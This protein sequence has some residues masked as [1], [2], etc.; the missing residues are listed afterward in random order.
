MKTRTVILSAF[1]AL[2][3]VGCYTQ[4]STLEQQDIPPETTVDSTGDTVR[5]VRRVDTIVTRE[6]EVCY[7]ERDLLGYPRLRC[8][9][10]YYPRDWYRYN[11]VPWWYMND[12]YWSDYDRCPRLYFYDPNCGCCKYYRD[13]PIYRSPSTG[14]GAPRTPR[15]N[16]GTSRDSRTTRSS[17][18]TGSSPVR[19]SS[20]RGTAR[21]LIE[22]PAATPADSAKTTPAVP[23]A[24]P[25]VTPGTSIEAPKVQQQP[26]DTLEGS[27]M[28]RSSR[29]R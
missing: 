22:Q 11:N 6:R 27:R 23:T 4:F 16:T 19:S 9:Q 17:G 13:A 3:G 21:K 25:A 12:P 5:V 8:Y 7:W 1:L 24:D 28:R 18:L 15:P 29:N 2:M 14:G 10:T 20:S 26:A